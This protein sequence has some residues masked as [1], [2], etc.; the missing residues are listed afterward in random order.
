[1]RSL[2]SLC[3]IFAASA[4]LA[5]GGSVFSSYAQTQTEEKTTYNIDA[6][7]SLI[8]VDTTEQDSE[9]TKLLQYI[10]NKM[11]V[12]DRMQKAYCKPY[13]SRKKNT[14]ISLPLLITCAARIF[15]QC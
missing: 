15:K 5:F 6:E 8:L 7:N 10:K 9:T 12:A 3:K 13:Q 14:T 11:V 1:M 2:S 4:M